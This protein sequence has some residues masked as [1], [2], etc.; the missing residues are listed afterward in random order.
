MNGSV[1]PVVGINATFTAMQQRLHD[2]Q[3]GNADREQETKQ[4]GGLLCD[5]VADQ[6]EC[7]EQRNQDQYA[8]E[9]PLFPD[10][11]QQE[12][13]VRLG[14]ET[15]FCTPCLKPRPTGPPLPSV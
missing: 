1:T 9:A 3:I 8:D 4:I 12:V 2:D 11:G 10:H 5:A 13:V 7:S 14:Q 15:E 6:R